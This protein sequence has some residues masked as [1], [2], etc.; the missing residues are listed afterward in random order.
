MNRLVTRVD[1]RGAQNVALRWRAKRFVERDAGRGS[2][3][4]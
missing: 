1:G 3:A 2:V 4:R